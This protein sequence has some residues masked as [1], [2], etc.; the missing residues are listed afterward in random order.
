LFVVRSFSNSRNSFLLIQ[1][2]KKRNKLLEQQLKVT[3]VQ[4]DIDTKGKKLAL[5]A[6]ASDLL[7]KERVALRDLKR[8]MAYDTDGSEA[9][10]IKTSILYYKRSVVEAKSEFEETAVPQAVVQSPS[11]TAASPLRASDSPTTYTSP[12]SCTGGPTSFDSPFDDIIIVGSPL[13]TS[14]AAPSSVG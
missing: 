1:V 12:S 5:V 8:E 3:Q 2:S 7:K 14:T 13:D 11:I 9:E 10:D 4:V 6:Q